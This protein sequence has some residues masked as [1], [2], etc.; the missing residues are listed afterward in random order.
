ML[1]DGA[2]NIPK[3]HPI[4]GKNQNIEDVMEHLADHHLPPDKM[5]ISF[6]PVIVNTGKE[7]VMFDSG[8]GEER[9]DKGAGKTAAA[10]SAAGY[11]PDQIDV[12]VITHGHP[13][14]VSGLMEDGKAVYPNARYVT[15]AM[16]SIISGPRRI[17]LK[18]AT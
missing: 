14:H 11:K 15:W 13:D 4:F 17:S 12:V 9:R 18:A 1:N 16:S 10:L 5:S 7:V 2:V 8:Y 6:T 3:V